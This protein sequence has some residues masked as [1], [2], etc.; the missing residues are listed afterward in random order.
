M[1]EPVSDL[2]VSPSRRFKSASQRLGDEMH[3][4]GP[5]AAVFRRATDAR[6]SPNPRCSPPLGAFVK[7][8]GAVPRRAPPVLAP[9][10]RAGEYEASR[11]PRPS[12]L[13]QL[14]RLVSLITEMGAAAPGDEQGISARQA[15]GFT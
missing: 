5:F 3:R 13:A 15:Q 14:S 11:W 6:L 4:K 1:V 8:A 12:L 9:I 10:F 7:S 2:R